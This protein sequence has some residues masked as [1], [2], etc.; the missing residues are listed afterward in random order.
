[1]DITLDSTILWWAAFLIPV[2]TAA[3]VKVKPDGSQSK[4][5]RVVL[6]LALTTGL[7]ILQEA[8]RDKLPGD[9]FDMNMYIDTWV[10][11][12]VLQLVAYLGIWKPS[13]PILAPK[14]D[15][16]PLAGKFGLIA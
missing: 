13:T 14:A 2:L 9:V 3:L 16:V 15:A 1:M 6:A 8:L 12:F 4:S 5:P 10:K 11:A 7:A